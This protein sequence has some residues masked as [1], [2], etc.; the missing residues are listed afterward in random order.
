VSVGRGGRPAFIPVNFMLYI[1]YLNISVYT[2]VLNQ[3]GDII[4][5]HV[6]FRVVYHRT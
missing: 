3:S 4:K 6:V 1:V 2:V 5:M